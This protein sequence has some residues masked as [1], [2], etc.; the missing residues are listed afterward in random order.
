MAARPARPM[1]HH[2]AS[3]RTLETHPGHGAVR[4]GTVPPMKAIQISRTGGPEVL[5]YVE[6]PAPAAG[7]GEV[8][9]KADAIGVNYFDTMIR[10]GRYRWM[11]KLPFVLGNEM[12]GTIAALGEGVT[13]LK[14]GQ[15]VFIAGYEIGNRGGLYAEYAAVPEKAAWPL[16][17]SINAAAATTLTNYQLAWILLHHAARG[18]EPDT[19]VVYG[20][21]GGVGT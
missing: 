10:T 8:L 4:P 6:V 15:P 20:A 21:A 18:V 17:P 14:V 12:S 2:A 5:D 16:P 13:T 11:P 19:V 9:V 1:G 3:H 7:A